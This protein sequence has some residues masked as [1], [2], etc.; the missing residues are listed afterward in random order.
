MYVRILTGLSEGARVDI[1]HH[2]RISISAFA[3][4]LQSLEDIFKEIE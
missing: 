3:G 1:S 4:F 2:S